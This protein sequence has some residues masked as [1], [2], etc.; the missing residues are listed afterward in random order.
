MTATYRVRFA[1]AL[2]AGNLDEFALS[3]VACST[4]VSAAGTLT[5]TIPIARG[6][7]ALGARINAIKSAA[8]SAVYVYRNGVPWWPGVLWTKNK[9]SDANGKPGVQIGAGTF[10][11][12]L[13]RVQLGTDLAPLTGTDQL[14]IARSLLTDMQSDPYANMRI[15]PDSLTATSGIIR[16]R[17]MYK[18]AA[19]PSYL[20]MLSDLANLDS[21]FEF[22]I[23]VL[24]DPTTGARTRQIRLA[25][26]TLATG[27]VHR[28]A[29]PG[30]ILSYN[31]PE[32]GGRGGTY[33]MATG[34]GIA[35]TVHKDTA[36]LNAGW[37]RTDLTT[38]YSSVTDPAVLEAHATADLALARVPV[39]VP[40]I[41]IR[42][43]AADITP[44]SIGDTVKVTIK[45]ELFGPPYY[46][47]GF[48]GTYRLVGVT[49]NAPERGKAETMD[50]ILN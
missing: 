17:V 40:A 23:Q 42:P 13:D 16:D 29:K 34:S 48:T 25:Y 21:G 46:P 7:T 35:S 43:D 18:A 36:M 22:M 26:P 8:S 47:A 3:G 39:S 24:V 9:T 12:Y 20:K 19:R 27:T 31:F 28:I 37:P 1:D 38:S 32:D 49:I 44:M 14:A 11:S 50:L 15:T 4:R 10:E 30:A 41:R 2:T 6:N 45:D 33:L 5:A